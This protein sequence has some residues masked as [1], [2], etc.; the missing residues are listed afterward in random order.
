MAEQN[1]F[2]EL[3][4]DTGDS[5]ASAEQF[6]TEVELLTF[7]AGQLFVALFSRLKPM[8]DEQQRIS[9]ATAIKMAKEVTKDL[10]VLN[11]IKS[12]S[13]SKCI[14]SLHLSA[15]KESDFQRIF[16]HYISNACHE[17]SSE[18]KLNQVWVMHF[19]EKLKISLGGERFDLAEQQCQN[20]IER[21]KNTQQ[22]SYT[23]FF[24]DRE[25]I[26]EY[27]LIL[28][29]L[30]VFL[31]SNN[32]RLEWLINGMLSTPNTQT[33]NGLIMVQANLSELPPPT[34]NQVACMLDTLFKN[35]SILIHEHQLQD[36]VRARL[37]STNDSFEQVLSLL[38]SKLDTCS[39]AAS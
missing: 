38:I 27:V 3:V 20:I 15:E 36:M 34:Y 30:A 26:A 24:I 5:R 14:S 22:F 23:A 35:V 1:S 28:I 16:S 19:V 37:P 29:D 33:K 32:K 25:A 6:N 31:T 17:R 39:L 11:K 18:S 8:M 9:L 21:M 4:G 13:C 7:Q 12:K 10:T 2:H